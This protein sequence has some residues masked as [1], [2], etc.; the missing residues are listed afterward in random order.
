MSTPTR[1]PPFDLAPTLDGLREGLQ[2]VS[3]DFVYLY[4]NEAVCRHGRQ[5]REALLGRRMGEVYPGIEQTPLFATLREV[6]ATGRPAELENLFE[7]PDGARAWFELRIDRVPQGLSILSLDITT[8]KSLEVQL[9]AAQRLEAVGRLAGGVAHDF[10]NILTAIIGYGELALRSSTGGAA[11]D[12]RDLLSAAGRAEGLVTQLLAFASRRV[13]EPRVFDATERI[14]ALG[15]ILRQLLGESIELVFEPGSSSWLVCID[16]TAFEQVLV[17]L[18][19]NAHDAMPRGGRLVVETSDVELDASHPMARGEHAEPGQYVMLAVTDTGTGIPAD[20]LPHV[21]DPFFTTKS[22]GA[23]LGLATSYGAVRQAGGWV[24]VYSEPARGTTFKVYL[25]RARGVATPDTVTPPPAPAG[26]GTET[27]L[28]VEDDEQIRRIVSRA[29]HRH[30]Y[31]VLT[32]ADP[33]EA[34][35][36]SGDPV[37]LLLTDVVLPKLGGQDLA[38]QLTVRHPRMRVLYM[39]GY[40]PH[41]VAERTDLRPGAELLQKPFTPDA[42]ARRVRA[43][44][45]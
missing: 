20:V 38:D 25:P 2:V 14:R 34:L 26:S 40:T 8:R 5:P 36:L 29:L 17:N 39:S 27:V 30:G 3:V 32:A 44:L 21:F 22:H 7:Y 11:E 15:P 10:A 4:V 45:G 37:D 1:P 23:G 19:V 33:D 9:A 13:V 12:L 18:A 41:T 43:V 16:P 28:V 24:W 42:L 35:A 31:R 6:L